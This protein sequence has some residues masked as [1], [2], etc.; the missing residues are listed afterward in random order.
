MSECLCTCFT[1]FCACVTCLLTISVIVSVISFVLQQGDEED[2]V[3]CLAL[4]A[5]CTKHLL[6]DGCTPYDSMTTL[7]QISSIGEQ[8]IYYLL[9]LPVFFFALLCAILGG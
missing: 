9:M 7:A 4:C 6:C 8:Y 1:Y 5:N 3:D 2:A